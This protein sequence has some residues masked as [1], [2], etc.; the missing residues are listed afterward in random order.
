M[1]VFISEFVCGGGWPEPQIG[2]SLAGEGGAMLRAAVED[3]ARIPGVR[4]TTTWDA[5][6]GPHPFANVHTIV[7]NSPQDE[8]PVFREL[9]QLC[10]ATLVIAPE[11]HELLANR[12][13]IVEGTSGRLLGPG[14]RA[15]ELCTDKLRLWSHWRQ[16]QVPTIPTDIC[17][18][19]FRRCSAEGPPPMLFGSFEPKYPLVVKPLDGAG[20]QSTYL[21]RDEAEF[22]RLR[23]T[24]E[25][26]T[27]LERGIW[28]PYIP[29]CAVSVGA[30]VTQEGD[31]SVALPPAEQTLSADGR[32]RYLGGHMPARNVDVSAIQQ[33]A[34]IACRAVKGLR[35]Y[36]GVDLIVPDDAP[37]RPLAVEIN[38]RLTTSYIGYRRLTDENLAARMLQT[39]ALRPIAWREGCVS[40]DADGTIQCEQE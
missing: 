20:S 31:S 25:T 37:D 18:G 8:L 6:L 17:R 26:D 14:S 7:V 29:G 1:R 32:F 33:V 16:Y 15:I 35:G 22:K 5:R 19:T 24:L 9:A 21:I 38:P 11:T 4:V 27:L 3:F 10:D 39:D 13:R 23:T 40:F 36:V 28:Q 12:A 30:F 34:L 2:G